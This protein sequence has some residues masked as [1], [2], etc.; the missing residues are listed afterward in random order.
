MESTGN[1][2][3]IETSNP[4]SE[5]YCQPIGINESNDASNKGNK[6]EADHQD[7]DSKHSA[8][9]PSESTS[10][11]AN[12]RVVEDKDLMFH[13]EICGMN[14]FTYKK[15][16]NHVFRLHEVCQLYYLLIRHSINIIG[17]ID[18]T[19]MSYP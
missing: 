13:C 2:N 6:S 1:D 16:C 4:S 11:S 8:S 10:I 5:I 15:L 12:S 7:K 9:G 19:S 14:F 3:A 17:I 18:V